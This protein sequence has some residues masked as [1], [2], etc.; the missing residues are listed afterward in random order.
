MAQLTEKEIPRGMFSG[1]CDDKGR[2]KLAEK[3]S[4]FLEGEKLFVT[5]FDGKTARIYPLSVWEETER[6]LESES[7]DADAAEDLSFQA[8]RYGN[9]TQVD[10]EGRALISPLLRRKMGIENRSVQFRYFKGY[11]LIHSEQDLE[12]HESRAEENLEEKIGRLR[13]KGI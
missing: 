4:R 13:K 11:I 12:Q 8:A 7:E 6:K 5:S 1:R 10:K 2:V 3:I 9:M